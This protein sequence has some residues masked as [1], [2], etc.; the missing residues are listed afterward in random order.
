MYPPLFADPMMGQTTINVLNGARGRLSGS[1]ASVVLLIIILAAAPAIE[2]IPLASLTGVLFMVVIHTFVWKSLPLMFQVPKSD[3]AVIL[4]VTIVGVTF[5]LAV[6]VLAGTALAALSHA[7]KMGKK[8]ELYEISLSDLGAP[9][10]PSSSDQSDNN[11]D[12]KPLGGKITSDAPTSTSTT[13]AASH[14]QLNAARHGAIYHAVR[15]H[16]DG[17]SLEVHQGEAI[18]PDLEAGSP[19]NSLTED[20][21]SAHNA[22]EAQS[23]HREH[24]HSSVDFHN[25]D[26]RHAVRPAL[27]P[28][29][30]ELHQFSDVELESEHEH[31]FAGNAAEAAACVRELRREGRRV[32]IFAVQ[33]T[34]FF[35]SVSRLREILRMRVKPDEDVVLVCDQSSLEDYTAIDAVSDMAKERTSKG[36]KTH[37]HG[38]HAKDVRRV[39]QSA[40]V[41]HHIAYLDVP[42]AAHHPLHPTEISPWR[43]FPLWVG[44]TFGRLRT[45][46]LERHSAAS[47]VADDEVQFRQ[48]ATREGDAERG[49]SADTSTTAA[50]SA[51]ESSSATAKTTEHA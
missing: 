28:G 43:R 8:F 14:H 40:G 6:S 5:N 36:A 23:K 3:S 19:R 20:T 42:D 9:E 2:L 51:V 41:G 4:V 45:L 18:A 27:L 44:Q 22:E 26:H 48:E 13:P 21:S 1:S 35:G 39:R 15:A 7:W 33:G 16:M 12:D 17:K 31:L 11:G 10:P 38:T 34:L 46:F 50:T 25:D 47:S 37:L 24:R 30:Q 49:V 32:R 29:Q